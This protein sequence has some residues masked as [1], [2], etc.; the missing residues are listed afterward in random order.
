[1]KRIIL[2]L[3]VMA[4][5]SNTVFSQEQEDEPE[6]MVAPAEYVLSVLAQCKGDAV[7]DEIEQS[8]MASY[9]LTCVNDELESSYYLPIKALPK[10]D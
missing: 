6:L 10:E 8:A 2:A 7:D 3:A 5:T 4:L 1:M 9:L